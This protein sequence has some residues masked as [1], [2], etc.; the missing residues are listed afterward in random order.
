MPSPQVLRTQAI[1]LR[2][3]NYGESDR[4]L[5]LLSPEGRLDV[6]AKGVRKEKSKLAG[7][8]EIFSLADIVVHFGRSSLGILTSAKMLHFYSHIM[9]DLPR[10]ELASLCMKRLYS[11]AE[12]INNADHF[13]ILR[14]VLAG[15][16]QNLPIS[17][18]ESWFWLNLAQANGEE[19]NL[20]CDI[21]GEALSPKMAYFWQKTEKSLQFNSSGDIKA[22]EI[23]L[24]RLMLAKPLRTVARIEQLE[25]SLPPLLQLAR[26]FS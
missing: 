1:V 9:A 11:A 10:L 7:G 25:D 16:D 20:I 24:A 12:Q 4:I 19:V 18:V 3:T 13:N 22:R 26:S 2:R 17:L 21:N 8:I 14:Q 23:K 6:M 5:N 15:L